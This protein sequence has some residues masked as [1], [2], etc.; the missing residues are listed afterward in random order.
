MAELE[1]NE[2]DLG[3]DELKNVILALDFV[4]VCVFVYIHLNKIPCLESRK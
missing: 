3:H 1:Y 4:C 2:F